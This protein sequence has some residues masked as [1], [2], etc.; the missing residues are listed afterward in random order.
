MKKNTELRTDVEK[1][2]K[3]SVQAEVESRVWAVM[4]RAMSELDQESRELLEEHFNGATVQSLSES[5]GLAKKDVEV[6]L[7]R[8]KRELI[9]RLRTECTVRQ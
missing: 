7:A 1:L 2:A 5:R 3:Q 6:W 4:E 9:K 8:T